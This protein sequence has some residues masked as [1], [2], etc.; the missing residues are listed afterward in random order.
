MT[1]S[2]EERAA[3][4]ERTMAVLRERYWVERGEE[5]ADHA[6]AAIQALGLTKMRRPP[7]VR[8]LLIAVMRGDGMFL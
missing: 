8:S 6:A 4:V 3:T 1:T 7:G 5:M 2:T